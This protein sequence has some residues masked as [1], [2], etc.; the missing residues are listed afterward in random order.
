MHS[1]LPA[2]LSRGRQTTRRFL[3]GLGQATAFTLFTVMLWWLCAWLIHG[4]PWIENEILHS[5]LSLAPAVGVATAFFLFLGPRHSWSELGLPGTLGSL[6]GLGVGV[7]GGAAIALGVVGVLWL[8]GWITV[9]QPGSVFGGST[10]RDIWEP[11]W[12]YGILILLLGSASEELLFHGYAFQQLIRATNAEIAVIGSSVLF[13]FL[14]AGNPG[15]ST[16]GLVNT[17]LFGCLFGFI[18]VRTGSLAI[19]IGVHFGW[20]FTLVATG[21]NLSGIRIKLADVMLTSSGPPLWSGGAY[22]PEA[23]LITSLA[24]AVL[25]GVVVYLPPKLRTGPRLWD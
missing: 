1:D 18:L 9:A 22:G 15:A 25:I 7:L 4:Q 2:S 10:P 21:V 24:V 6:R 8:L 13:G 17:A 23:S 3:S 11:G 12:A 16:A 20:N 19:P 5:I 14:H